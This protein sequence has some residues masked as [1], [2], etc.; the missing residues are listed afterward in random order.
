MARERRLRREAAV[1]DAAG[2][3]APTAVDEKGS[4][5]LVDGEDEKGSSNAEHERAEAGSK[6]ET[7]G[8]VQREVPILGNQ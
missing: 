5:Q 7:P 3:T 4:P 8:V 2:V 6:G 1:A